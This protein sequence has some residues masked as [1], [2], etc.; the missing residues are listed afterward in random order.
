MLSQT[1]S[2][3]GI[4]LLSMIIPVGLFTGLRLAGLGQ[5]PKLEI[6]TLDSV[7]WQFTRPAND[8]LMINDLLNAT[9]VDG[10]CQMNFSVGLGAYFDTTF[11]YLEYILSVGTDFAATPLN[12]DFS[13]QNV[14]ITFG[15]DPQASAMELQETDWTYEN[16]SLTAYSKVAAYSSYGEPYA[17][18]VGKGMPVGVHCRFPAYWKLFTPNNVTSQRQIELEITYYNGTAYKRVVQPFD[19]T[20][21]GS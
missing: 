12:S 5:P 7:Q 13:I 18:L 17:Q 9:F 4:L 15:K 19:L 20:L 3:K 16:L 10:A 11:H 6:I 2:W 1:G 21:L 8:F 14:L